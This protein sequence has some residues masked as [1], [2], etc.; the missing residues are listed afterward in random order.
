MCENVVDKFIFSND[1]NKFDDIIFY[2]YDELFCF[3]FIYY[4]DYFCWWND[5]IF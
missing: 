3:F 5:D 2:C 1:V 4:D